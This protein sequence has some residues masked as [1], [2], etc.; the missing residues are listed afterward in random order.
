MTG[1]R[2]LCYLSSSLL[3]ILYW[4]VIHRCGTK[5]YDMNIILKLVYYV[6]HNLVIVFQY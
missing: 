2:F 3:G 4:V 5:Y 6:C 1:K